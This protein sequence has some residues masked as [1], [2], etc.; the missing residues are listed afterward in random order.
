MDMPIE[1]ISPPE[2]HEE[3]A[4]IGRWARDQVS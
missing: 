4:R 3:F 1:V 2:L